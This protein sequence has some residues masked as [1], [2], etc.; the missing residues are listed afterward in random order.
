MAFPPIT[1]RTV[2]P[3]ILLLNAVLMVLVAQRAVELRRAWNGLAVFERAQL[4]AL[5]APEA[6]RD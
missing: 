4:D 1:S 5:P 2:L 3:W 6:S